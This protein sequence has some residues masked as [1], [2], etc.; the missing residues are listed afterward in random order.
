MHMGHPKIPPQKPDANIL[1][2]MV[3]YVS[4]GNLFFGI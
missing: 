1:I 2:E 4:F 3:K